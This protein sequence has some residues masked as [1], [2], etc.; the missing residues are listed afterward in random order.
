[1]KLCLSREVYYS[2]EMLLRGV[3]FCGYV[4][5]RLCCNE[6]SQIGTSLRIVVFRG[7]AHNYVLFW[8]GPLFCGCVVPGSCSWMFCNNL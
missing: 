2:N 5:L 3:L 4:I 8:E 1:M 7:I 6:E